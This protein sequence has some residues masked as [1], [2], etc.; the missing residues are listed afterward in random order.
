M[1]V[2]FSERRSTRERAD[3]W[4]KYSSMWFP[5]LVSGAGEESSLDSQ[6]GVLVKQELF[7]LSST[8]ISFMILSLF[9]RRK[10]AWLFVFPFLHG[11]QV[12]CSHYLDQHL[13]PDS[14][15]PEVVDKRNNNQSWVHVIRESSN[16]PSILYLVV[17]YN[18]ETTRCLIYTGDRSPSPEG[19]WPQIFLVPCTPKLTF[20]EYCSIVEFSL[21]GEGSV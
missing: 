17:F 5:N 9:M 7:Y 2:P 11:M 3:L 14:H 15:M 4:G 13:L 8:V 6:Y 18:L 19:K 10:S 16:P 12:L 1:I 21:P 20:L